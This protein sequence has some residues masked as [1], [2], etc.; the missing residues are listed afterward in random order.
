MENLNLLKLKSNLNYDV[1]FNLSPWQVTGFTDAEGAFC[2]SILDVG[3][4][5]IKI[6][7]EFKITQKTHSE[8]VLFQFKEF[9]NCGSV[10]IDNRKTNTMKYHVTSLNNIMENIIPHFEQYPCLTSKF[11]NFKDWKNIA[12]MFYNKEHFSLEGINLIKTIVS[13]MNKKRSFEDKFNHCKNNL[14]I[15]INKD[16]IIEVKY[17]LSAN[18]VQGFIDGEGTFYTYFKK[19]DNKIYCQSSLEIGQNNHDIAVLLAIK[20]FFNGGYIKPKYNFDNISECKLSRSVNRYVLRDT[21]I[22]IKVLD[23][24]PLITRKQLDYIDWKKIVE[25]KKYDQH[26]TEE[27]FNLIQ[28][29]LLKMNSKRDS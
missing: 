29:I 16:K 5:K 4:N 19:V 13:N 26:K 9:F 23:K 8:E 6:K 10:V 12:T 2:C 20:T 22:I 28:T 14:G 25:L 1:R 21:E 3:I 27:G 7:L 24:F 18:W 11:L 17:K 15:S